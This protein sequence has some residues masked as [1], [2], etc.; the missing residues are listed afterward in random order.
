MKVL[1]L[2]SGSG[3]PCLRSQEGSQLGQ[4]AVFV[5]TRPEAIKLAPVIRSLRGMPGVEV[6]VVATGQHPDLLGGA[7]QPFGITPDSSLELHRANS[8]VH[9]LTTALLES[10]GNYLDLSACKEIV[11]Q[12]DT[13]T[14][15]CAG[16]AGFY[17][18][19]RVYHVEAGLRTG[20]LD[21]PWPE[22][23][24]RQMLA[25]IASVHFAPT[26]IARTNLLKEGIPSGLIE[27]TGNT[28]VDALEAIRPGLPKSE[29][30]AIHGLDR[31]KKWILVTGHRREHQDGGF[32][33]LCE[34]LGRLGSRG[35][36]QIIYPLHPSPK[37]REVV[38]SGLGGKP[39]VVLCAPLGYMDFLALLRDSHLVLTDSGGIQEEA[40]SFG[41]PAL[42][43][44]EATERPEAVSSG[45]ARIV[46][47]DPTAIV[48]EAT[49]LLEDRAAWSLM[50]ATS[51]P[52]GDGRASERISKR[53]IKE[54][55]GS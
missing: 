20:T 31:S 5:G 35:D 49:R 30:L 23:A 9:A 7:L 54:L 3:V 50:S 19:L 10:I 40:P 8:S 38:E 52:F 34:A 22:E 2:R 43:F 21:A 26:E 41:V 17:R 46:G 13:S 33:Q 45:F 48:R 42:V 11:V 24:N 16:L 1:L 25:R 18:G 53:I 36:C 32:E 44:R 51:N 55:G 15:F 27:V 29:D 14:A 6:Q 39:G 4:I 28:V 12:G 37:V 47:L